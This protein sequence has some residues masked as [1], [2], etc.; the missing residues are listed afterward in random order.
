[1]KKILT[2]LFLVGVAFMSRAD[3][4]TYDLQITWPMAKA[5]SAQVYE[6]DL[7]PVITT[8]AYDCLVSQEAVIGSEMFWETPRDI[9]GQPF[10]LVNPNYRVYSPTEEHTLT[11]RFTVKKNYL[12][13][14][15][16]VEYLSSA[17]GTNSGYYDLVY[18]WPSGTQY[19]HEG[20]H[21]NRNNETEGYYST[22]SESL[23]STARNGK[24]ELI[25]HIY[26]LADNKQLG[27]SNVTVKGILKK[28]PNATG[29]SDI[30]DGSART[31]DVKT[32]GTFAQ[33]FLKTN[34]NEWIGIDSLTITGSLNETDLNSIKKVTDL[35]YLDLSGAPFTT[36]P[37]SFIANHDNIE[38]V[39]LPD[40]TT[41][42][43]YRAFYECKKLE[44]IVAANIG[45]I[46]DCAF[47]GCTKLM[48]VKLDNTERI[49]YSAFS[50]CRLLGDVNLSRVKALG[51]SSFF[52]CRAMNIIS[53]M[54][55]LVE[56]GS[57][58]FYYCYNIKE[59][60]IKSLTNI[61]ER[62]FG[63]CS[64]LKSIMLS[65]QITKIG[66]HAFYGC[67][68]LTEIKIPSTVK[69]IG[70][71]ALG[72]S[73]LKDIR[74]LAACPPQTS[75]SI[76][77]E[78]DPLENISLYVPKFAIDSYRNTDLWKN[79]YFIKALEMPLNDLTVYNN[80]E[81]NTEDIDGIFGDK[82]SINLTYEREKIGS[83]TVTGNGSLSAGAAKIVTLTYN[84]NSKYDRYPTLLTENDNMR[85]DT[86]I[87]EF[88][89]GDTNKW[90]FI[91]LPHDV[92][93]SD[94]IPA[95]NL[96]WA[97][98]E[99]DGAAR[100]SNTTAWKDLTANDIMEGGRGYIVSVSSNAETPEDR[101]LTFCNTVSQN[102]NNIFRSQDITLP[103]K[104]HISEFAHNQSWNLIGN[105][106]P[107]Y[108]NIGAISDEFTAPITIWKDNGYVAYSPLD[109]DYVLR[110]Y[111]ALFVQRPLDTDNMV[112]KAK[113]R[114]LTS[115][116]S[117]SSVKAYGNES[118]YR[119]VFDFNLSDSDRTRIVIN[120]EAKCEYEIGR[121]AAKFFSDKEIEIYV[122]G[123]GASY[124]IDE[125]PLSDGSATLG[126]KAANDG[127][128]TLSLSGRH[129]PQW[130]VI[131]R[132][133][134]TG[135]TVNLAEEDYTFT[136]E[137]GENDSRF[138]ILF[139]YDL[140]SSVYDRTADE[141]N[142]NVEIYSLE[143][144]LIYEGPL[145]SY[146]STIPS[147]RLVKMGNDIKKVIL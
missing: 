43:E 9:N 119:N 61:P 73:G 16:S 56:S 50:D 3:E 129:D 134:N 85:A 74:V 121:D 146:K 54:D 115:S 69:S 28:N 81:I 45:N 25:F 93:V 7:I 117:K 20:F 132:D 113:G 116:S 101:T 57:Y 63:N 38:T 14:P 118:C 108:Y 49:G 33:E 99:Y 105:P 4:E 138:T 107:T 30:P 145:A 21:P 5:V 98:R 51:G 90:Y 42:I 91:S 70:Q 106:Y 133:L 18:T 1:M 122:N 66:D 59:V 60:S 11:F 17:I 139:T 27:F 104:E 83:L 142:S 79:F 67:K 120:P 86:I 95:D 53:P 123:T 77:D 76:M 84:N 72:N 68:S 109:D 130:K 112:F 126:I 15:I 48:T 144:I 128:H 140:E 62:M 46:G 12:F 19:V 110:P 10:A 103:L 102:K 88:R 31:I 87:N 29:D 2:F 75:Y 111:E 64:S 97:I 137:A 82:P 23:Q 135:T 40:A 94:I 35:K 39:I 41:S 8:D 143:G 100:A 80:L 32:P 55:S 92:K 114:Q 44:A 13:E 36:V 131:L 34:Y 37:Q 24:Y 71:Y 89:F 147:V 47:Q 65:E 52:D 124:A 26:D 136:T 125:R 96:F 127:I 78:D 141:I 58:S 22:V 6:N